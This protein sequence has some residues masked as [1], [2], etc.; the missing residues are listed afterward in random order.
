MIKKINFFIHTPP[1]LYTLSYYIMSDSNPYIEKL[2][3]QYDQLKAKMAELSADAKIK[4]DIEQKKAEA[5]KSLAE[6][7]ASTAEK[8][9][10][11]NEKA[12]SAL[13]SLEAKIQETLE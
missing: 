2:S 12:Q 3:A 11:A 9:T 7:K 1:I 10:E 6:L 8:V 4:M 13:N 5:E